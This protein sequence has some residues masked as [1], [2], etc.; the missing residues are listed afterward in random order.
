[1]PDNL[2]RNLLTILHE[3]KRIELKPLSDA[4]VYTPQHE[5]IA[6]VLQKR[7]VLEVG[8]RHTQREYQIIEQV[9]QLMVELHGNLDADALPALVNGVQEAIGEPTLIDYLISVIHSSFTTEADALVGEKARL[10]QDERIFLSHAIGCALD[11]FNTCI[12]TERPDLR[13]RLLWNPVE[14]YEPT[15]PVQVNVTTDVPPEIITPMPEPVDAFELM[16]AARKR[17]QESGKPA[18]T[19]QIIETFDGALSIVS[20]RRHP[21]NSYVMDGRA[22]VVGRSANGNVYS[23]EALQSLI[24][25]LV[26]KPMFI[27][28][29][30][31]S[32]AVDRPERSEY[33]KVGR[34]PATPSDFYF[35]TVKEGEHAG[36]EALFYRNGKLSQT[37]D[38]LATRIKEHISGEQ[39]INAYGRGQEDE[40][41]GDF[42]V[43][44]FVDATSLDFVTR[45]AAGGLGLLEAQRGGAKR[46]PITPPPSNNAQ[47]REHIQQEAQIMAVSNLIE[48]HRQVVN[49]RAALRKANREARQKDVERILGEALGGSGLPAE[50]QKRVRSLTEAQ[51]KRFV[52][53]PGDMPAMDSGS[54]LELIAA[55]AELCEAVE[56]VCR[57]IPNDSTLTDSGAALCATC[58][59]I[60]T[61]AS[62]I[63]ATLDSPEAAACKALCDACATAA[64][65]CATACKPGADSAA[66][67][68]ACA[69]CANSCSACSDACESLSGFSEPD[70][71]Q[72]ATLPDGTPADGSGNPA[73]MSGSGTPPANTMASQRA[74]RPAAKP[75]TVDELKTALTE[76]IKG[77]KTYLSTVTNAGAISGLGGNEDPATPAAASGETAL[78]EA[79]A[80]LLPKAQAKVAAAG[81][82]RIL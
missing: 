72:P 25:C 2:K 45:G 29:P 79:F 15:L 68:A 71:A 50:G 23:K 51:V 1:M 24:P 28:H 40:A 3:A 53:A 32:E 10:S 63:C 76:A 31:M 18:T 75:M 82:D 70:D 57:A 49:L 37:V 9:I 74:R 77:E 6:E 21:D 61:A 66:L 22:I 36:K 78:E 39:S 48:A 20:D 59:T 16:A 27:D 42:F 8:A 65:D 14:A 5:A 60:C 67:A 13:L 52:E 33:D 62:A 43:E 81:R 4:Q 35:D 64:K 7:G 17:V 19:R 54:G 38:W 69:T 12:D 73:P 30:S 46:Q 44:A 58:S 56:I 80:G 55:C 41:S 47:A 34:L 11:A 26:N